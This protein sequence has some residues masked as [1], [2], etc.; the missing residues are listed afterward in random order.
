[1]GKRTGKFVT[2]QEIIDEVGSDAVRFIFL[3]RRADAQDG[4]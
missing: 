3:L 4:V 1:M 2:L